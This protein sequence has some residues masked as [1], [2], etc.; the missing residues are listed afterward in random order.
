MNFK[1]ANILF[2]FKKENCEEEEEEEDVR[3]FPLSKTR[4]RG[5]NSDGFI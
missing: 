1:E 5:S 2:G 3:P 4:H